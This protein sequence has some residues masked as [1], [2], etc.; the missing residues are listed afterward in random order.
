MANGL[1]GWFW[2]YDPGGHQG[3]GVAAIYALN[4]A[5]QDDKTLVCTK[6]TADEVVTWFKNQETPLAM[7]IDTLT[8]W[9][10]GRGSWRRADEA[11]RIAYPDA[12]DSVM[13]PSSLMG[14]MSL[15]GM[16]VLLRL[17]QC[18]RDLYITE[19][20]PKVLHMAMKGKAY[21]TILG[22]N[23]GWSA[24]GGSIKKWTGEERK[25]W[26]NDKVQKW[27][28]PLELCSDHRGTPRNDHEVDALISAYAA[29][30]AFSAY[31]NEGSGW[32]LNLFCDGD[33]DKLVG[34]LK[35]GADVANT[36]AEENLEFP[37]KLI[38][39][40]SG[41]PGPV[42]YRWPHR[43]SRDHAQPEGI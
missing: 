40:E 31:K 7:G 27:L 18:H 20:H 21:T 24:V 29:F 36:E 5:L 39:P 16:F 34:A 22:N 8:C 38:A 10:G 43:D 35:K 28:K 37:T 13:S 11:L 9:S 23:D 19:T 2:G 1:T 32:Q 15:N 3:N 33:R 17:R 6:D 12:Q 4:G 25:R 42:E 26:L 30:R 14:A 41:E